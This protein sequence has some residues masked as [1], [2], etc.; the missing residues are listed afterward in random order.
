VFPCALWHTAPDIFAFSDCNFKVQKAKENTARVVL[1]RECMLV[2]SFTLEVRWD[3]RKLPP[4]Q[5][6]LFMEDP[7][8]ISE[9]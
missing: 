8:R 5:G 6:P 4:V 3:P 2:N 1:W 9:P 7:P